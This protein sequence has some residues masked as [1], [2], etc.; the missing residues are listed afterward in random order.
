MPLAFAAL[1]SCS[2][3]RRQPAAGAADR[4][5]VRRRPVRLGLN[6]IATAFTYQAAM[7]AW[8]GWVAVVLLSSTSPSIRRS[9]PGSAGASGSAAGALVL[10]LAGGWAVTEWLRATM[11]TG[12]AWNPVGVALVDDAPGAVGA[13]VGT[14]GLS[15]L[16]VLLG[17]ALW[18]EF[19]PQVA[20]PLVLILRLAAAA[21]AAARLGGARR[22]AVRP[23][24]RSGSSS[25]TSARRTS[26]AKA[27][28][29]EP[30]R[31]LAGLSRPRPA[32][33]PRCCSGPG[34]IL[35][36]YDKAHLVPYG[37]YL[38][39]RPLLSA[40]GLSRSR[41]ATST[42]PP[43]P[44]RARSTCP[45]GARS[46]FQICY[47]IIFSGQ[48][49]DRA[50]GR[51]SSSIPSNDAWFGRWGPPQHLAQARL[52]AAEEGCRCSA[53]RRP[54]SA[55][56]STPAARRP[57]AAVAHGGRDRRRAAAAAAADALRPAR[58]HH[59]A[60][61]LAFLLLIGGHCPWDAKGAIGGH[62]D[63]F[64]SLFPAPPGR[65]AG[66]TV[67]HAQLLSLHVRIRFR[68][69]SRQ[70]RRPDQRRHRR[71]VPVQGPGSARRLRDAD[72]DQRSSSPARSAAGHHGRGRQWAPGVRD[73]IEQVVRQTVKRIGYEQDGFH[74][75]SSRLREQPPP[76][77]G[78]HR[79]GRRR[80]RQQGRRRRRPGHHVRLRLRRDARP[81]A[82]DALLQ[83]QDPRAHGRRPPLGRGAVPGARR[84]EPGHPALRGRQAGRRDR[85][86]RLDPARQGL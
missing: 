77:V 64:I 69:P 3:A 51:T 66:R 47:E 43:G 54:A 22:P 19:A 14:Y 13:L 73:E 56:S 85:D 65:F 68:R 11:F 79:A 15:M 84:Q 16:V 5:A 39:M 76:A 9:P 53:R 78:A 34:R 67:S 6:W 83:P 52:R 24:S 8:L 44:G 7:P 25:R 10:A 58:Q 82:G 59:P 31:R 57:A 23:A 50:T 81:D 17:G 71:P 18:L 1:A 49:V 48:V 27:S 42:S 86:R 55:R 20:A 4:L 72:D 46:G 41:P 30:S 45:A 60:A 2:H 28:S 80:Q 70:G 37:E 62:K 12:F 35:G 75:E 38:P 26:G 40:I 21:V 33:E 32:A 36:R 29:E 61:A 74:W 63:F